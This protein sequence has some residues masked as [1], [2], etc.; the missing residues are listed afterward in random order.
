MIERG[1]RE[2]SFDDLLGKGGFGE[3]YL[4][5]MKTTGGLSTRVAIKLLLAG[6]GEGAQAVERLRDEAGMLATVEH[7]AVLRVVDVTQLEGGSR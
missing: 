3:V 2:F 6:L 7:P 4:G 5:T 1:Y